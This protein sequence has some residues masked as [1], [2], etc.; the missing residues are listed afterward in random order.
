MNLKECAVVSSSISL[1]IDII[2]P[3]LQIEK[4]E[5]SIKTCFYRVEVLE[6][7]LKS[8]FVSTEER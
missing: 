4:A 3:D 5:Q 7:S 8:R 1:T 2:F 6:K